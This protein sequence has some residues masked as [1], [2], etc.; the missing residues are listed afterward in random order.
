VDEVRDLTGCSH[1]LPLH[2]GRAGERILFTS[3]LKPGQICVSNTHFD[4]THAN[5]TL[6]GAEPRDLP[7]PEAADLD[8]V[9][10]FKGDI[11]L[12]GLERI[13]AGPEGRRVGLVLVTI[14]NNG[15]GA[16]PVS[17]ANLEATREL[18]RRH[19]VPFFLDAA[20]FAENAWLVS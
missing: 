11:D 3:L 13:L 16:Q 2:Q 20:R 6:A 19:R 14:T 4:T 8:S 9:Q 18:C 10:P 1:I 17:M 7:C 12:G 5:V 15:L